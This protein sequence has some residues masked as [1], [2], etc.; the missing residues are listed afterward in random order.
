MTTVSLLEPLRLPEADLEHHVVRIEQ[1]AELGDYKLSAFLGIDRGEDP[2]QA[3]ETIAGIV[4]SG[5]TDPDYAGYLHRIV[6]AVERFVPVDSE[7][8]EAWVSRKDLYYAGSSVLSTPG[9]GARLVRE[10]VGNR[11]SVL[12]A[13]PS[14]DYARELLERYADRAEPTSAVRRM[15]PIFST[16]GV[17]GFA[18][19]RWRLALRRPR[20]RTVVIDLPD[21]PAA[22]AIKMS[23]GFGWTEPSMLSYAD[24]GRYPNEIFA[25]GLYTVDKQTRDAAKRA[26]TA[27]ERRVSLDAISVRPVRFLFESSGPAKVGRVR[28]R[29]LRLRDRLA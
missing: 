4:R 10:A 26:F 8:H 7:V 2:S 13:H 15:H 29:V 11:H 27:G 1:A 6:R 18:E 23:H 17:C 5:T 25:G 12:G 21:A 28:D 9:L 19:E 3:V 14:N 24:L 20:S 16:T 22:A